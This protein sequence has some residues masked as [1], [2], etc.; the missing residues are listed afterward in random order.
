MQT[1]SDK[2][3]FLA[4]FEQNKLV[5]NTCLCVGDIS[6]FKHYSY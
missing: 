3:I 6:D 4:K 1:K 5:Q 2:L